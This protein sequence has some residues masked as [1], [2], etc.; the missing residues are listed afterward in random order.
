MAANNYHCRAG[1]GMAERGMAK[2]RK[3]K[4]PTVQGQRSSDSG[5]L[6]A[7]T[8]AA[9]HAEPRRRPGVMSQDEQRSKLNN[10][11]IGGLGHT[12]NEKLESS[13]KHLRLLNEELT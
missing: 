4:Q 8:K 2:N 3:G 13:R 12:T 10:F 1:P 6:P 7:P 9:Q 5:T 11:P